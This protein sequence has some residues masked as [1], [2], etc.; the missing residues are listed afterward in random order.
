[1]GGFWLVFGIIF[2]LVGIFLLKTE[3]CIVPFGA[4]L[5]FFVCFFDKFEIDISNG[6]IKR[7]IFGM[8]VMRLSI[9][10]IKKYLIEFIARYD[11]YGMPGSTYVEVEIF[12]DGRKTYKAMN[13]LVESTVVTKMFLEA[14]KINMEINKANTPFCRGVLRKNFSTTYSF[15]LLVAVIFLAIYIFINIK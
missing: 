13:T 8:T 1:M 9:K 10:S 11:G 15:L 2:F 5:L 7:K 4:S 14:K 12:E 6:Q 3:L